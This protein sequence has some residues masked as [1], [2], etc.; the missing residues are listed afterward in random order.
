M[1]AWRKLFD[2]GNAEALYDAFIGRILQLQGRPTI[3]WL[4]VA[5]YPAFRERLYARLQ[6]RGLRAGDVATALHGKLV[7]ICPACRQRLSFEF[8]EGLCGAGSPD[9]SQRPGPAEMARFRT[10]TC[11]NPECSCAEIQMLW[12]P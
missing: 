2:R 9:A 6:A 3:C 11:V 5:E 1:E 12:K 10:G 8:L 4:R 7:G